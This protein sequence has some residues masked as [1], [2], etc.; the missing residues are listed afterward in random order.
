M[1]SFKLCRKKQ[2]LFLIPVLL[3]AVPLLLY[4]WQNGDI[5]D[6]NQ[7][8][9]AGTHAIDCGVGQV[10]TLENNTVFE[11]RAAVDACAVAAYKAK[12]PFLARYDT[13]ADGGA[14]NFGNDS[15]GIVGTPQGQIYFFY[16]RYSS[17]WLKKQFD[18]QQAVCPEPQII[19]HTS[20]KYEK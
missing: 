10:K 15:F 11:S 7:R 2:L 14:N 8:K 3:L 13:E 9:L 16:Y 4:I 5:L 6:K 20:P 17:G 12:K 19:V 18:Y 1:R